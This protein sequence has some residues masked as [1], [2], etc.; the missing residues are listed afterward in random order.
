MDTRYFAESIF[1]V[2]RDDQSALLEWILFFIGTMKYC[3]DA[4]IKLPTKL[5]YT[6]FFGQVNSQ[7]IK[8]VTYKYPKTEQE[9]DDFEFDDYRDTI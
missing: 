7:E 4:T 6:I 1:T 5:Y 2:Q 8:H 9:Q 3:S